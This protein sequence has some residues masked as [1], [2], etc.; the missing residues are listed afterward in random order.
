MSS[1]EKK[2]DAPADAPEGEEGAEAAP[3]RKDEPA[4]AVMGE[5]E[6]YAAEHVEKAKLDSALSNRSMEFYAC[7]GQSSFKRYNFHWLGDSDFVYATG[8]TYQIYNVVS[9]KRQVF[10]G[11]DVDGIGSI[12][13]HP[14]R[15]Y[16]AVAEKGFQPNIYIYEY[17]SLRLYRVCRKGTDLMYAHVEFSTSGKT[18]ASLG[19][20]PDYTLTVWDWITQKV[21]LKSKAFGQDVFRVSFSPYTDDILFTCGTT[22]IKFW[23]MAQTFTGLKLQGE[24]AKFG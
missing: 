15:K 3:A 13:V 14:S 7:L 22:H 12:A 20:A 21:V 10:H 18:L 9:G 1:T 17:P 19:G 16:F 2:A 4:E 11:T 23:K 5:D 8:N 24:I 6:F